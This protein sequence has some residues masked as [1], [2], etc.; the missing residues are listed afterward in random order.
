M[1]YQDGSEYV[2]DFRDDRRHGEG[3]YT[4]AGEQTRGQWVLD[5][6]VP[7]SA[8]SKPQVTFECT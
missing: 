2:G 3:I 6:Y 8:A 5:R 7:P 4:C 1:T